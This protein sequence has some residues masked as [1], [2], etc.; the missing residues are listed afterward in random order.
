[1]DTIT[2]ENVSIEA[3]NDQRVLQLEEKYQ[4]WQLRHFNEFENKV[5][6]RVSLKPMSVENLTQ[7]RRKRL[8]SRRLALAIISHFK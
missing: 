3:F 1:M 6:K 8:L 7:R 5:E 4:H 2:D